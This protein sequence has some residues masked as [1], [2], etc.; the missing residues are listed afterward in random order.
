MPIDH[1]PFIKIPT[2]IETAPGGDWIA[3]EKIHGAQL[4]LGVNAGEI[5][6]GK[7]K[8][9]LIPQEPFFGWQMLRPALHAAARTVYDTFDEP[10][11]LFLYGE[12]FGGHY[13]H[14]DVTAV[15][16]LVPVQT[17]VWYAP[18]LQYAVFDIVHVGAAEPMYLSHDR[19]QEL[20]ATAGLRTP[21]L[22]GRGRFGELHRLPVRYPSQVARLLA[23]PPLDANFAEG[24]VL[25][26]AAAAPVA[27]RPCVKH[28]IPEF[29][30]QR[31]NESDAFDANAHL[32]RDALFDLAARLVNAARVASARSKV[33]TDPDKVCEEIVLDSLIDL[34]DMLP[35][36]LG[37]LS[38]EEEA[39]LQ[40][41]LEARARAELG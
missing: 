35:R 32:S 9:W 16:G 7:R 14:P 18:D 3:T 20:L 15:A 40:R 1:L 34:H 38:S 22:L 26:P 10:G 31:F 13:P 4:V 24:Y 6:I 27:S 2:R 30:E 39:A 23:L 5:H 21:P 37:S 8:A 25:K 41:H 12:L 11:T 17:G 29:D 36:R 19:V 33:G 28:K